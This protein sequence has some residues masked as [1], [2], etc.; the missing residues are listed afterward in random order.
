[1]G[2]VEVFLKDSEIVQNSIR[3]ILS[4]PIVKI[5][6]ENSH[7][8]EIQLETL[9]IDLLTEQIM[10]KKVNYE[11]KSMMRLKDRKITRGAFNRTLIQARKNMTRSILTIFLL[12]YVRVFETS[13]LIPFIEASNEFEYYIK[14]LFIKKGEENESKT[15]IKANSIDFILNKLKTTIYSLIEPKKN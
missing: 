15:V 7:L 1:M 13:S 8:T 9:L 5:L 11:E 14:E 4:D 2:G 6:L 10:D 3:R 12:S